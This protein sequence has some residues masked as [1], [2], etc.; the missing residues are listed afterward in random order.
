[1]KRGISD[2]KVEELIKLLNKTGE[3]QGRNKGSDELCMKTLRK[4]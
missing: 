2:M 3:N 1:M 4:Q